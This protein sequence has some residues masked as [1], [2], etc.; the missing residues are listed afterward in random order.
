M[1]I[2]AADVNK[3]RGPHNKMFKECIGCGRAYEGLVAENQRHM[4]IVRNECGFKYLRFHGLLHDDMAVCRQDKDGSLVYNWQYIDL[5]YDYMLSLD[6]KPFV[7]LGFMP[8][9]LAS[10]QQTIFWWKGNITP[11]SSYEQW[12]ELIYELVLHFTHRYGVDEVKQWYF[13]VWNEPNLNGFWSG[14]KEEYFRLYSVT[15]KAVKRVCPGY[16]VGGPATAGIGWITE[17]ID[18]CYNNKVPLDFISTHTYGVCV[19]LDEYG[20]EQLY[21]DK[22]PG[23]VV[24]DV[25]TVYNWVKASPMPELEIHFTEWST[26]CSPRDNVHDSYHSAP[27]ILSKL[28]RCEGFVD[29]MSYWVYSDIFEEPGPP[30]SHFHGG[31]G[32]L[33][34]QGLKKPSFFAYKFLNQLGDLELECNDEDAWVC[35][36]GRCVQALF[37]NYTYAK[38]QDAPN[39][40]YYSRDLPSRPA[41]SVKL[42]LSGLLPGSY[43]LSVYCAGYGENDVYTAFLGMDCRGSLTNEQVEMLNTKASGLPVKQ[44]GVVVNDDGD[45]S[46]ELDIRENEAILITLV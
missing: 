30:N 39:Q 38:E 5:L 14:G 10:G 22:N 17:F 41:G 6:I 42:K 21:L 24:D 37:W 33:N 44:I 15:A 9:S 19:H 43:Q 28:K 36:K 32:L 3:V 16:K 7:E 25:K 40:I 20:V 23:A 8:Q 4:S 27:Y 13:E 11:P 34:V 35:K 18:F 29:S 45:L 2:I 12:E 46:Y 26:S 31:F 1:R